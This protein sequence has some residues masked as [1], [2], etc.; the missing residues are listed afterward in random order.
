MLSTSPS[1]LAPSHGS[2]SGPWRRDP[3]LVP[4]SSQWLPGPWATGPR[5]TVIY[6]EV[7]GLDDHETPQD[8][9]RS[10]KLVLPGVNVFQKKARG[11]TL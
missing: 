10:P 7:F 3:N 6:S 1:T 4:I 8:Q 2:C 9:S 5:E 11:H